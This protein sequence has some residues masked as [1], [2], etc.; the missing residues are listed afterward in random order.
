MC[1]AGSTNIATNSATASASIETP[2]FTPE[3]P[4]VSPV[5]P[6]ATQRPISPFPD[7]PDVTTLD[8]EEIIKTERDPRLTR[9]ITPICA[10][11]LMEKK[12]EQTEIKSEMK[13]EMSE[14]I[15][16]LKEEIR[17]LSPFPTIPDVSQ[18]KTEELLHETKTNERL[19]RS[20]SPFPETKLEPVQTAKPMQITSL[21]NFNLLPKPFPTN[22]DLSNAQNY[23]TSL[24]KPVSPVVQSSES[25]IKT[26]IQESEIRNVPVQPP[27]PIK[28]A[29]RPMSPYPVYIPKSPVPEKVQEFKT[30]QQISKQEFKQETKQEIKEV[31]KEE[32]KQIE[33]EDKIP[34]CTKA[35]EAVIGAKPLFGQLDINNELKKAFGLTTKHEQASIKTSK[36]KSQVTKFQ[37]DQHKVVETKTEV[38]EEQKVEENIPSDFISS[39]LV[40]NIE[41]KYKLPEAT[42]SLPPLNLTNGFTEEKTEKVTEEVKTETVQEKTEAI[43]LASEIKQEA[44]EVIQEKIEDMQMIEAKEE[45]IQEVK[46]EI[47]QQEVKQQ[48]VQQ[49]A[50]QQE[51]QVDQKIEEN[52]QMALKSE[53]F[54]NHIEQNHVEVS[55]SRVEHKMEQ[56]YESSQKFETHIEEEYQTQPIQSLIKSF[57]QNTM[58]VM[59]YKT[60]NDLSKSSSVEKFFSIGNKENI[61]PV[62]DMKETKMNGKPENLYY[63]SQTS[64]ENRVFMPSESEKTEEKSMFTESVQ[65]SCKMESS[66]SDMS[67]KMSSSFTN[68]LITEQS[69]G[70]QQSG[71][72][73]IF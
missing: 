61:S 72:E 29:P 47:I 46:Q 33:K 35:P 7:I 68:S 18:L 14:Q 43:S 24:I 63:V 69:S 71:K 58:P 13:M 65:E 10:S 20:V 2:M 49:Q 73:G 66:F 36:V 16:E 19:V 53:E 1:D 8:P 64:V 56:K 70:L 4:K 37:Q 23:F 40:F 30:E 12:D 57:E 52:K 34:K 60:T 11:P 27:Q 42:E 38:Q 28:F 67:S 26:E 6:P 54:I 22:R 21:H 25:L 15:S 3:P 39:N 50:V 55:S 44:V 9:P 45:A 17:P 48:E 41:G 51:I 32:I 5:P 62:P 31:R 59:K